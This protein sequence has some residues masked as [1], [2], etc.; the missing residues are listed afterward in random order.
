M[1]DPA[2]QAAGTAKQMVFILGIQRSGTTWL[3]NI[4]DASPD[5]LLFM[6]PFARPLNMFPEFPDSSYFLERSP[7][8]LEDLLRTQLPIRLIRNKSFLLKPSLHDPRWFRRDQ[9]LAKMALNRFTPCGLQNRAHRF[10][11]LNLNRTDDS[12]SIYPK[13]K[14]PDIWTIKELRLAGKMP[15]VTKAFPEASFVVVMRHPCAN[16]QSIL[17]WFKKGRLIELRQDLET[18]LEKIEIQSAFEPYR[19]LI[20]LCHKGNIT[21]KVALYWRISYETLYHQLQAHPATQFLVYEQL[22][23]QPKDIAT[24]ML[25]QAGV[26]WS[27]SVADYVSVSSSR[28]LDNSSPLMTM[29]D[30]ATYYRSWIEKISDADKQAVLDITGDSFLM[31]HFEAYY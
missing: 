1:T 20:R 22:A 25:A 27:Q 15:L 2:I 26:P 18:Y 14:D 19:K 31:P 8:Y 28:E 11:G 9:R 12:S 7:P 21:H 4:F 3:S 5:V 24:Q 17:S 23:L 6:E 13:Q 30:S 10:E 16:V 29:R